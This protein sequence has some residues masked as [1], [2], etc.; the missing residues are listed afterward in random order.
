MQC[1]KNGRLERVIRVNKPLLDTLLP[2]VD[3]K[4]TLITIAAKRARQITDEQSEDL[5]S[6]KIN[7]VSLALQEIANGE[8]AWERKG[9]G[10]K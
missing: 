9:S 7:P 1:K 10:I 3:A 6:G 8:I 4:Y 2:K 5:K